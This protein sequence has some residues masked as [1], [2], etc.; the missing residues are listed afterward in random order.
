[1]KMEIA[2]LINEFPPNIR[3][4]I[5][6]YAEMGIKYISKIE[7]AEI[8]VFTTNTGNLPMYEIKHNIQVYRP[9]NW[10]QR[11]AMKIRRK[12]DSF[13]F[14]RLFLVI[15][16]FFNNFHCYRLIK[17]R[18]KEKPFELIVIHSLVHSISGILCGLTLKVPIVFHKHSG[19]FTHM[20]D[21]WRRDPLKLLELCE[22]KL[23]KLSTKIIVYTQEMY[24]T[25]KGYGI[26][27]DKLHI[28]PSGYEVELFQLTDLS[29]PAALQKKAELKNTLQIEE[30]TKV[31]LYAGRLT[32]DK[33]V[34]SLVKAIKFLLIQ[35]YQIKLI[36]VG[37]GQNPQVRKFIKQQG[38]EKEIHAY[39]RILDTEKV[40]Y[41]YAI[42]DVCIFPSIY[43][44]PFG[45]VA[46]EAMS[47]G[48]PTILG[49]GFS[50]LFAAYEGQP[51]VRYV[52]GRDPEDIAK[53][54]AFVMD[55]TSEANKMAE[56]GRR[57]VE[58]CLSWSTAAAKTMDVY[59][60]AIALYS[61]KHSQISGHK[62][63]SV[64]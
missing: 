63:K 26:D 59:R 32:K 16:V 55:N 1:M 29:E 23:E 8:S 22:G 36:F 24:D 41:H 28:V 6:R 11:I 14:S 35:G 51:C 56:N 21:W 38:L 31:I 46:L 18:N 52:N 37:S 64:K 62:E 40:L 57:F 39:Y 20:K 10:I 43:N 27:P 60:E 50:K 2:I 34:F 48:I 5:G 19:E 15:N 25:N 17:K 12:M 44:E 45:M 58:N 33:G 42:A 7:D 53:V 13:F 9:M 54:L 47:L 61:T 49:D 3:S 30:H 4:G